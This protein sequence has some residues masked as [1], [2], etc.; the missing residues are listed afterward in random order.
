M[1][2]KKRVSPQVLRQTF[3]NLTKKYNIKLFLF[4]DLA[5]IIAI[6]H[7]LNISITFEIVQLSFYEKSFLKIIIIS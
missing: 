3:N 5:L 7:Y 4:F 6:L 1:S 2:S